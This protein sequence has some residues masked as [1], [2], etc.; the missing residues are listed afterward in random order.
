MSSIENRQ[1]KA[2][3]AFYQENLASLSEKASFPQIEPGMVSYWRR[4]EWRRLEPKDFEI[5]L[6]SPDEAAATLDHFWAGTALQGLGTELA[7][8]SRQFPEV[9][10]KSDVSSSIYEMF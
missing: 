3:V 4:R 7:K 9:V 6:G 2:L 10:E 5:A 1:K 8:L